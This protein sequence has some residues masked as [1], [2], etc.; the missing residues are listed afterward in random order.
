MT[1]PRPPGVGEAQTGW[2][3]DFRTFKDEPEAS[4]LQ[5]LR[6]FVLD[7]SE[8][9]RAAW[10]DAVPKLQREVG[11]VLQLD[12]SAGRCTAILEYQLPLEFRRADA[13]LLVR[14]GVLVIELKKRSDVRDADIDQAQAYARDLSAYHA[15][16]AD[17]SVVPV[18]V[19]TQARGYLGNVRG[20]HVC[21]PDHLDSLVSRIQTPAGRSP[22]EPAE[23]LASDA[24]RPLPTLV[25]AAR[26]LF[27]DAGRLPRVH[28]AAAA[29]D[30]VLQLLTEIV[31]DAARTGTRRLILLTGVPGAGK[32]LVG[33]RLVHAHFIDDLA[34]ARK[35][36][37]PSAAAAFLSGNMPL[38][39]VLQY[40]LK[41]AHGAGKTF[42]R[43]V[44]H[45][46]A[47]YSTEK[48][49]LPPEHV[50][51]FDEAQRAYDAAMV[52]NI[53]KIPL[54]QARSEPEHFIEFVDRIPEW[55]VI[56]GLIGT[57]QEINRGEEGGLLP[58]KK[59][60]QSSL[61]RDEWIVH[62]PPACAEAFEDLPVHV[63]AGLNLDRSLRA[64]LVSD[65]HRFVGRLVDGDNATDLRLLAEELEKAGHHLRVSRTLSVAENYLR[66]RYREDRGAR[67]GMVASSRDKDLVNFGIEPNSQ[68]IGRYGPWY[69]DAED[70]PRRRSCRH[71]RECITEFGAQGLELD[72]VLLAWGGDFRRVGNR[73]SNDRARRHQQNVPILDA[74]QLRRNC[75]RVLLTRAR[76]ATIVFMPPMPELDE[77]YD[78]LVASGF[79][80]LT[81]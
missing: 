32:T 7:A 43:H 3:S 63:H 80:L 36:G 78:H 53:H 18:L 69:G 27:F 19:P 59:A 10:A 60:I 38:V 31:H 24:Y 9:Q 65:V 55:A 61:R 25:R 35:D 29:T 52:A 8:G 1:P 56:V 34:V 23:F 40:E 58:W 48:N 26:Q 51:V 17:R 79:R 6:S 20:V 47:Y 54:Q 13:V 16:C 50:L 67:F 46:V 2:T 68:M 45:Y 14:D 41:G 57:G 30:G 62:A 73:W 71:L 77:T 33:L 75:Y 74:L 49:R 28:R 22:I 72:A 15:A 11:E 21:G 12:T 42:V 37:K 76:D 64:H 81:G 4:V 5:S 44:K 66:D 70:E 39:D